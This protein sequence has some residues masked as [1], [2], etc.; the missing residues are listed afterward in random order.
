MA[1]TEKKPAT[2][3]Q[4][5]T[6]DQ[7]RADEQAAQ[8]IQQAAA[9]GDIELQPS[10]TIPGGKYYMQRGKTRWAVNANGERIN[11][12]GKRIDEHGKL[13]REE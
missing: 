6:L 10:E 8:S 4:G 13:L 11:E 12:D 3:A 5:S 9:A 7:A 2:A 1:D